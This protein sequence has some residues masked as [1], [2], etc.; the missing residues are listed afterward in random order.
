MEQDLP[1]N[2]FFAEFSLGRLWAME[3]RKIKGRL[4]SW[5]KKPI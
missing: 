3:R 2:P 4:E 1:N 5:I